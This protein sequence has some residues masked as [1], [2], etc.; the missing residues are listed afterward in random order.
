M[1]TIFSEM[2]TRMHFLEKAHQIMDQAA[3]NRLSLEGKALSHVVGVTQA[4]ILSII[5]CAQ[6]DLQKELSPSVEEY[7]LLITFLTFFGR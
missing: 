1:E 5:F 4:L 3:S 6:K 2:H 7:Y